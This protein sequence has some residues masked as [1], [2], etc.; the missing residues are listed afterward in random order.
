MS[1]SG[2]VDPL[3][4]LEE[5]IRGEVRKCVSR[6]GP[7]H[8]LNLGHGVIQETPEE[9]VGFFVDEAKK[10]KYADIDTGAAE[11]ETVGV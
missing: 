4:L 8:V 7:H 3:V 6:A 1:L 10:F 11:R 9:A 2:N 5:K